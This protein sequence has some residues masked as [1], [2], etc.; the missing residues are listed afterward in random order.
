MAR[1]WGPLRPAEAYTGIGEAYGVHVLTRF[2]VEN[3]HD[4][5]VVRSPSVSWEDLSTT[6][7]FS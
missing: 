4:L 3:G 1:E 6:T 2:F 7:S 5:R